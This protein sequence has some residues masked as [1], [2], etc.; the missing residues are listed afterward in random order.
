MWV[1][2]GGGGGCRGPPVLKPRGE[3]VDF[4]TSELSG[5][6]THSSRMP[7]PVKKAGRNDSNS[8]LFVH[9]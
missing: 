3:T 2:S 1:G 6:E 8:G 4:R 5:E 9:W 7:E